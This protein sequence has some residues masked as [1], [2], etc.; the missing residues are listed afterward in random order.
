MTLINLL[1]GFFGGGLIATIISIWAQSRAARRA[2]ELKYLDDALRHVYGPVLHLLTVSH[3]LLQRRR[4][5]DQKSSEYF[6][7]DWAAPAMESVRREVTAT[8]E[9]VNDYVKKVREAIDQIINIVNTG[10]HLIDLN[11][12]EVFYDIHL[13]RERIQVEY[14]APRSREIPVEVLMKLGAPCFYKDEWLT[15]IEAS[16]KQKMARYKV[17]VGMARGGEK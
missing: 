5:V 8:D 1:A 2:F 7:R 9:A 6:N 10:G 11:D 3:M 15:K 13:Q 16:Y 17:L 4:D 12:M 14:D